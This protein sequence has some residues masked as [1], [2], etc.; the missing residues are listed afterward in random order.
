MMSERP[1]RTC[2][3]CGGREPRDRLLRLSL[4]EDGTVVPDPRGR[5]TGRGAWVHPRRSCLERAEGP[6]ALG[7]A[8]RGKA[9]APKAGALLDASRASLGSLEED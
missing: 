6:R 5:A 8:F 1:I 9:R 2:I 3:G 7:R 4:R